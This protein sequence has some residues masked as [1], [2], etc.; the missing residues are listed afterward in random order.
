MAKFVK[1]G[2]SIN[3]IDLEENEILAML[4]INIECTLEFGKSEIFIKLFERLEQNQINYIEISTNIDKIPQIIGYDILL[5][6]I[7]QNLAEGVLFITIDLK[8]FQLKE[9]L[10][11]LIGELKRELINACMLLDYNL[12]NHVFSIINKKLKGGLSDKMY[13]FEDNNSILAFTKDGPLLLYGQTQ[14][15]EELICI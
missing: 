4:K 14:S 2:G 9:P 8:K 10:I 11:L 12:Q 13:Y 7:N 6:M 1:N 3:I 15:I 5:G